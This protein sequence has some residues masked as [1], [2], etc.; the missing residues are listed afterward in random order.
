M[1]KRPPDVDRATWLK[2]RAELWRRRNMI[3][4]VLMATAIVV[5]LLRYCA[6]V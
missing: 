5:V 3:L 2:Q 1:A 6:I 4:N